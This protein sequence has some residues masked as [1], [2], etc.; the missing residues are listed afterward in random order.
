[1][2]LY[3]YDEEQQRK[4]DREDGKEEERNRMVKVLLRQGILSDE[5]IME[6]AEISEEELF[7]KKEG[8]F[9]L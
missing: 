5:K 4:W 1:M 9:F 7:I 6:G 3:E 2:C 8:F